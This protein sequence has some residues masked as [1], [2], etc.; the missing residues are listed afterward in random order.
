MITD[1]TLLVF[2]IAGV[3][4]LLA[5]IL[6]TLAIRH[7]RIVSAAGP[8]EEL[9]VYEKRL[10]EKQRLMDDLE[11]ELAKRRE[12]MTVVAD[13]GSEVDGLR[14]QK[15]ELLAE[16]NAMN[17]KREEVQ[18]M[19][20][21]IED[22]VI[23]RQ[24]LEAEIAPM[25]AEYLAVKERLEKA[26]ELVGRIDTLTAEHDKISAKVESM[27]DELRRLEEAEAR[28][29]RL[30]DREKSLQADCARLEGQAT[31]QRYE[32]AELIARVSKEREAL[33]EAH[34][35]HT[36]IEAQTAAEKLELRRQKGELEG[37]GETRSTLE[38]RLAYLRGEIE[39]SEG[40]TSDE[41]VDET[42]KLR[43]LRE[44]PPVI[45]AMTDWPTADRENETD[46]LKRVERRLRAK[47]LDYPTRTLHAF[48]PYGFLQLHREKIPAHRYGACALGSGRDQQSGSSKRSHDDDP[49]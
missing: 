32:L 2:I 29:A 22:V 33:A 26:E 13:I 38:A 49:A 36:R 41:E 45:R 43:E 3:V 1:N 27:R 25:R 19:R 21:E 8:I 18:A 11:E 28:V 17:E 16:W 20:R 46:A 10:E 30:E 15:E 40:R 48:R 6:V 12:A 39:K 37:L 5:V 14:R 42:D 35:E 7:D 24:S 34:S 44:V 4:A 23:E 47:G 31:S 9:T